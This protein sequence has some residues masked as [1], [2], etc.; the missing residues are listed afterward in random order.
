[1]RRIARRAVLFVVATLGGGC[2]FEQPPL[3][4]PDPHHDLVVERG[5]LRYNGHELSLL[6]D[7]ATWARVLGQRRHT[8]HERDYVI[9]EDLGIMFAFNPLHERPEVCVNISDTFPRFG[10]PCFDDRWSPGIRAFPGRVIV[11]GVWIHPRLQ[12]AELRMWFKRRCDITGD[13][14]ERQRLTKPGT[15]FHSRTPFH[16]GCVSSELPIEY[17]FGGH[18]DDAERIVAIRL[19]TLTRRPWSPRRSARRSVP[20]EPRGR[21]Q[22]PAGSARP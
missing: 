16:V 17:E 4:P 10:D 2:N 12:V 8:I 6:D 3:P 15:A 14:S 1:M 21:D 11:E 20:S 9:F 22:A 19:T 18:Y 13:R 7:P 5:I